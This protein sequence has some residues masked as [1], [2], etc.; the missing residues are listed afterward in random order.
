MQ[1]SK[2]YSIQAKGGD[3]ADVLIYDEI[4]AWGTSA[5][6]FAEDFNGIK[7]KTINLRLNTPGGDVFDGLA[8]YNTIKN[9]PS[10]VV[11]HIDG[12][13]ASMGSIIALAG[14]EVRIAKNG[15]MMI[16]NPWTIAA[17]DSGDLRKQADMMDKLTGTMAQTYAEATG[18]TPEEMKQYMSDE[19]WFDASEA[20]AMGLVDSITEE[21]GDMPAAVAKAI[22]KFNK[23]PEPLRK[24]AALHIEK[25][26]QSEKPASEGAGAKAAKPLENIMNLEQ[27]KAFAAENPSAVATYIDQG[28]KAGA[29]EARAAELARAKAIREACG[30]ND[31]VA[32]D[33][34]LAG[35]ESEDATQTL[36]AIAKASAAAS[37]AIAAKDAEI[38]RLTA[39]LGTQ[40]G[41]PTGAAIGGELEAPSK[42]AAVGPH[43]EAE[44]QAAQEWESK[45]SG[46]EKFQSKDKYVFYR[47]LV[48]TGR[49]VEKK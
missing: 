12:L 18:K 49:H 15:Y 21:D 40:P 28:K 6:M 48:L 31:A 37:A 25:P 10:Q 33:T 44:A 5:K 22:G 47:A 29:S 41:I 4:G 2:W 14:D 24:I 38:A 1:P 3:V 36:A 7:A 39:M 27:F 11:V 13:A 17:G 26:G 23:T 8:I 46:T 30:G 32:L 35:K 34:F 20:L 19:T 45:A 42:P 16:H 9:H 43:A